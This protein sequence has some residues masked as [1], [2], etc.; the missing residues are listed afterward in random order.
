MSKRL[1]IMAQ[2]VASE[3]VVT[4]VRE[5]IKE[6]AIVSSVPEGTRCIGTHHGTF[7][8]DEALACALLKTVPRFRDYSG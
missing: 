1:R 3:E 5:V 6:T 2:L 7:H 8:C 4:G